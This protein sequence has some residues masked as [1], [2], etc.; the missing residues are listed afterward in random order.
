[1][2]AGRETDSD[3]SVRGLNPSNGGTSTSRERGR[4]GASE[5][6]AGSGPVQ[7]RGL[8]ECPHPSPSLLFIYSNAS[9]DE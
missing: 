4:R 3:G 8:D 6:G 1:V 2:E 7:D 5:E 9:L